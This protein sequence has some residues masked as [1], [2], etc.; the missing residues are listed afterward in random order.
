MKIETLTETENELKIRI[1]GE[2]HTFCQ[3]LQESLLEDE[4]VE[5]AGYRLQHP[6]I[7]QPIIY[8]RVKK[9][10][11]RR[12]LISAAEKVG[13]KADEFKKLWKEKWV[14]K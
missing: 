9:G 13:A 12:A 3:A 5:Y 6:L 8:V 11:P 4:A 14:S 10:S 7:S 1:E 2:G